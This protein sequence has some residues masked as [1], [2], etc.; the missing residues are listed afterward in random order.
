MSDNV[1]EEFCAV[2]D[3]YPQSQ[4]GADGHC[5]LGDDEPYENSPCCDANDNVIYPHPAGGCRNTGNN[6]DNGGNNNNCGGEC[7]NTCDGTSL[8]SQK[9]VNGLCIKG[10]LI[11]TDSPYCKHVELPP[12]ESKSNTYLLVGAIILFILLSRS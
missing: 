12:V 6:I 2:G 4:I 8:Y 7:P 3:F 9:C 1:C 11:K 5:H 10:A